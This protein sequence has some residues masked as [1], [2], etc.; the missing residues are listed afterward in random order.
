MLVFPIVLMFV[1]VAVLTWQ[2]AWVG[3]LLQELLYLGFLADASLL[4]PHTRHACLAIA[5]MRPVEAYCHP[6]VPPGCALV[7]EFAGALCRQVEYSS[8]LV[9]PYVGVR[10]LHVARCDWLLGCSAGCLVLGAWG[11]GLGAWWVQASLACSVTLFAFTTLR[12]QSIIL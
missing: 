7:S 5:C 8:M 1:E 3:P 2:Q 4:C 12:S 9:V 11:L 10:K 6:C